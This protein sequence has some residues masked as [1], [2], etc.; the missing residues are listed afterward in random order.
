MAGG[1]REG[2][3]HRGYFL[4]AVNSAPASCAVLRNASRSLS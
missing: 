3:G 2:R 1:K 4:P